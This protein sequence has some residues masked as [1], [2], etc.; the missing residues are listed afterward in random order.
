M[1]TIPYIGSAKVLFL[2]N[3]ILQYSEILQLFKK[4]LFLTM[5]NLEK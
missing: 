4:L 1:K 3:K 5:E 2:F